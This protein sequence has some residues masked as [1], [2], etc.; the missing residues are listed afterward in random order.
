MPSISVIVPVYKVESYIHRCIDSILN[1]TYQNFELILVDDGSPDNCGA[2]CDEYANNDNRIHVIH[3]ENA[4]LSVA[5]N[6]GIDWAFSNSDSDWITFI[7]SD[8]W[9]HPRYLELLLKVVWASGSQIGMCGYIP[10][11]ENDVECTS[12]IDGTWEWVTTDEA[13]IWDRKWFA[14]DAHAWARIYH[15]SL[16]RTVRFPAGKYWE[17]LYTTYKIMYQFN[18]IPV[19]HDPLYYFYFNENSITRRAWSKH[20]LD[21]ITAYEENLQFFRKQKNCTM[22]RWIARALCGVL[23][24]EYNGVKTADIPKVEKQRIKVAIW[25]KVLY[26]LVRYRKQSNMTVQSNFHAYRL[27]FKPIFVIYEHATFLRG[28][29]QMLR[30]VFGKQPQGEDVHANH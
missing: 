26:L 16:L 18:R 22:E 13:Y 29:Y 11:M 5:R 10:K 1:Q 12:A 7:D 19:L 17:D 25:W 15:K 27:V 21:R 30:S 14:V 24:Y 4:G 8:D 9:V 6:V 23:V 20:R 2:I 28:P 3:Q